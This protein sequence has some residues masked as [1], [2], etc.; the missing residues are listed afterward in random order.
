MSLAA[1]RAFTLV[2]LLVVIAIV[3]ILVGIMIPAINAAREAARRTQCLDNLKNIGLAA[4]NHLN[5][6]NFYMTGG[7]GWLWTGDPDRGYNERQPGGWLYNLLPFMEEGALHDRGKGLPDA[8]KRQEATRRVQT[9]L[10]WATC[11][12][13]RELR[14]SRYAYSGATCFNCQDPLHVVAR[15]DYSANCHG[16]EYGKNE[17]QEGPTSLTEGDSPAYT[18]WRN[19]TCNSASPDRMCGISFERSTVRVKHL[20]DGLSHTYLVGERYLNDDLYG[21]GRDQADNEHMYVGF[22]ND[23][24]KT[25]HV[26]P[27]ADGDL[28]T[29]DR[30]RWGSAHPGVF[31]VVFCDGSTHRIPF[32]ID[33]QTHT[34]LSHRSDGF[35]VDIDF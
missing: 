11:P 12:S 30:D 17:F 26:Q 28:G 32:E 23:M 35:V 25:G 20:K 22:D 19:T 15:S 33:L 10:A 13:R 2:E 8:L 4:N 5:A 16:A 27:L 34:C 29:D 21:T 24:Y 6:H 1:R 3:G 31:H 7:W 9:P 18:G 14:P